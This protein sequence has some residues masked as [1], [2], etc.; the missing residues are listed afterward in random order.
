M[1]LHDLPDCIFQCCGHTLVLAYT[2][3]GIYEER[4]EQ[5]CDLHAYLVISGLERADDV[6][7]IRHLEGAGEMERLVSQCSHLHFGC[8]T[9][10]QV[11]NSEVFVGVRI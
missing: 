9:S 3:H 10:R 5:L 7:K 1:L 2:I 4:I 6:C 11:C 8:R